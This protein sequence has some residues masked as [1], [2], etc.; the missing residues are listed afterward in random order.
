MSGKNFKEEGKNISEKVKIFTLKARAALY[1][2]QLFQEKGCGKRLYH[3]H[4]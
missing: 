4:W 3:K 2:S 1:D